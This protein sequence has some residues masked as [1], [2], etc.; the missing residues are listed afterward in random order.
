[1]DD[2][3]NDQRKVIYHQRNDILTTQEISALAQE[4]RADV[5]SN[6]VDT[7]MPPDSMEEQWDLPALEA[8]LAGEFRIHA[9]IQGW[10]KADNTLDGEDI[11]ERLI[12][13]I[14]QEYA[15]KVDLIGEQNMQGFERNVMLQVIDNQWVSIW[16]QWIICVRYSFAGLC[17][18]RTPNKNINAK[19][20]ICSKACGSVTNIKLL[21][22]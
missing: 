5:V 21:L 15:E 9:D 1:M 19:P 22:Y 10:L 16:R 7:H 3:A 12:A 13:Q 2:V 18:K 11:K 17:T 8:I 14:E 6:L 20:L 4:I